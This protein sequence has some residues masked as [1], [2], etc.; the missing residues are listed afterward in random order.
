[1]TPEELL[2]LE[3]LEK[4]SDPEGKRALTRYSVI[5]ALMEKYCAEKKAR[6][7]KDNL[8][9]NARKYQRGLEN[10]FRDLEKNPPKI[11][12]YPQSGSVKLTNS[13]KEALEKTRRTQNTA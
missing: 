6:G 5:A 8:A 12:Y 1:M 9:E 11:E 13:G 7:E 2:I 3:Y 4:N 10:A